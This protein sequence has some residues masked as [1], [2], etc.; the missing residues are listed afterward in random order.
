MYGGGGDELLAGGDHRDPRAP[1]S[2]H[3]RRLYVQSPSI[4]SSRPALGVTRNHPNMH[5]NAYSSW[6]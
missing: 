6:Q 4:S 3:I 2:P 5:T 1:Y